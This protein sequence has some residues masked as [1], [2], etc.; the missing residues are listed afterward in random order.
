MI[1]SVAGGQLRLTDLLAGLSSSNGGLP[2]AAAAAAGLK[3]GTKKLLEKLDRRSAPVAAPLPRP[4]A[5]RQ[6][7]KAG[8]DDTKQEVTKWQPIVKVSSA[9]LLV[10]VLLHWMAFFLQ[11]GCCFCRMQHLFQLLFHHVLIL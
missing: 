8:Y 5:E 7:R 10:P 11:C 6:D 3:G 2:A 4:V 1:V 9:A